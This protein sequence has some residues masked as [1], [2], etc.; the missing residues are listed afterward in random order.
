MS[1]KPKLPKDLE[2]AEKQFEDFKEN[3]Q[4]LTLDRMN[5]AP[6]EESEPQTKISNREAQASD[7]LYLK[8]LRSIM[9]VNPRT[10]EKEKF[11]EKFRKDWEFDKE[12]VKF[13]AENKEIIGETIEVWTHPYG[14]VPA[15]LWNIP[16]NKVVWGPRHLAEQI[17][18][19]TYHRLRM[20]D[21][22][23]VSSDGLGTY[24]GQIVVDQVINRLDAYPISERKSVFM[25]ASGF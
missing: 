14:G 6:K 25:G 21:H 22:K 13:I 12:Y 24:T 3:I 10:G 1:D 8:P 15:E 17:K 4:D 16:T 9:A 18:R 20:D 11:N 19:C 7:G 5:A 2:K 23:T